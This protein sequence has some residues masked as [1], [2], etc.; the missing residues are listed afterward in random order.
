MILKQENQ[1][2]TNTSVNLH[3]NCIM[4]YLNQNLFS[5]ARQNVREKCNRFN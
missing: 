3:N 1:L 5:L 4:I 2:I